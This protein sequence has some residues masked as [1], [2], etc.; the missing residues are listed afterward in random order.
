MHQ[1]WSKWCGHT[2]RNDT[3]YLARAL[4]CQNKKKSGRKKINKVSNKLNSFAIY[5]DVKFCALTISSDLADVP[6]PLHKTFAQLYRSIS[7]SERARARAHIF[8]Q[9]RTRFRPTIESI[10]LCLRPCLLA[11]RH[12]ANTLDIQTLPICVHYDFEKTSKTTPST[13]Q[14][15]NFQRNPKARNKFLHWR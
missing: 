2:H 15:E 11:A 8:N 7:E 5:F 4:V 13:T 14:C 12:I 3:F 10:L 6:P 9:I 1:R